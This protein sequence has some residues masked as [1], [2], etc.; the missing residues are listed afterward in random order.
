[1]GDV[2]LSQYLIESSVL[3]F[4]FLMVSLA[5]SWVAYIKKYYDLPFR[6]F[7]GS[8]VTL[9]DVLVLFL[10]FFAMYMM[11]GQEIM[12]ILFRFPALASNPFVLL[13]IMQLIVFSLTVICFFVYG[14][15]QDHE[16]M[17]KVFKDYDFP[18][19]KPVLNDAFLGFV[20][21]FIAIPVVITLSQLS[22]VITSLFFG[23][24]EAGQIAVES[25]KKA[26]DHPFAFITVLI[27]I[28]I[29]APFLEEYLFR[30]ILQS[31]LRRKIGPIAAIFVAAFAF[32]LMHFAP[33]QG[34]T[35]IPLIVSLFAFGCYLGFVYEKTRSLFAPIVLHVTFNFISVMR[36]LLFEGK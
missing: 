15:F 20:S 35:N 7:D 18:G 14:L 24:P 34:W 28:L 22:E 26:V 3:F 29:F 8:F 11:L 5:I 31:W 21:W 13:S 33:E 25:L 6:N 9:K 32:A 36:I 30:G 1:M 2:S 27:S 17:S 10:I 16:A 4:I 12:K 19:K 23:R